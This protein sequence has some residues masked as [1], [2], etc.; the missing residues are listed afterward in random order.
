M[1][2]QEV[3]YV[4]ELKIKGLW[5][6]ITQNAIIKCINKLAEQNC[7]ATDRSIPDYKRNVNAAP[8]YQDRQFS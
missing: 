5:E 4:P 1:E 3:L 8:F 6:Q 7:A 2:E